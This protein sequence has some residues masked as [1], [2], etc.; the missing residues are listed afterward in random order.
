MEKANRNA[1]WVWLALVVLTLVTW[2]VGEL[3]YGGVSVVAL[4]LLSVSLKGQLVID[5]FMGLA[6]VDSRWK[7][8][9]T[10]WL[11]TVVL[12]IGL[13]YWISVRGVH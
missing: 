8:V 11:I 1:F 5:V 13:A 3:G 7:W 4:L 2:M 10:G 9:L 12:L 6:Q